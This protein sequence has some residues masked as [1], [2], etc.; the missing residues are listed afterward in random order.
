MPRCNINEYFTIRY[1]RSFSLTFW[2]EWEG[3][4]FNHRQ[5]RQ[6]FRY[7]NRNLAVLSVTF[8]ILELCNCISTQ[9]L[10]RMTTC[11]SQERF[12]D[13][14][15]CCKRTPGVIFQHENKKCQHGH[16]QISTVNTG[17]HRALPAYFEKI[18]FLSLQSLFT[19]LDL[20]HFTKELF[21]KWFDVPRELYCFIVARISFSYVAYAFFA[22][23]CDVMDG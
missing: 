8:F 17:C 9:W 11:L 10:Y 4:V 3:S 22:I 1:R 16:G 18:I 13:P 19:L 2:K 20:L 12:V 5:H 23:C 21:K 7:T 14:L 6:V 15:L